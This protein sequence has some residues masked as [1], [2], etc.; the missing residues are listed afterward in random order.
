MLLVLM[1]ILTL[2]LVGC[3][4]GGSD[5][6][7]VTPPVTPPVVEPPVTP[8]PVVNTCPEIAG[9]LKCTDCLESKKCA[10]DNPKV[11]VWCS[12]QLYKEV[13]WYMKVDWSDLH[14]QVPARAGES[15]PWDKARVAPTDCTQDKPCV[16]KYMQ[17]TEWSLYGTPEGKW[18][19]YNSK[20]LKRYM[21]RK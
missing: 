1:M 10:T 15:C 8:P 19:V 2:A 11:W 9:A 7:P 4:N 13:Y 20:T 16:A 17:P 6:P 5:K 14:I 21:V 18:W 3:P 12:G